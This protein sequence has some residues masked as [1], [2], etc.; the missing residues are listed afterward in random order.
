MAEL[1]IAKE[2][3]KFYTRLHL[4]ELTGLRAYNL[5][6]LVKIL[7]EVPDSCVYHHT[8]KFLQ[9]HLY[10]SPEPPNDFA[11][12]TAEALGEARLAERLAS[13]DITQFLTIEALRGRIV[14]TIEDY[15]KTDPSAGLRTAHRG[16]EFHFIKAVSFILP[17]N[18]EAHDLAEFLAALR[19]IT[20]D[21]VY[22]HM[23]EARLRLGKK[24]NDFSLWIEESLQEERV[25]RE[26]SKL[27]PYT[28]TL[29][30][31]R[32]ALVRIVERAI[33]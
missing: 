5:N 21:S 20:I 9:Q 33:A 15:L 19:E 2:P 3:F 23:F 1:K 26:I 30:D 12:W 24:T 7:K 6:E 29:D 25:A 31:L 8:H 11:Y 14:K 22:F 13:V 10:L 28:R 17:T 32:K 16:A 4:S 27:D 18:Y